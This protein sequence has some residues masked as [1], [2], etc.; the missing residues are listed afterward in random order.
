MQEQRAGN[1]EEQQTFT[2][3]RVAFYDA[4]EDAR[5]LVS[6]LGEIK[7]ANNRY[8]S[9]YVRAEITDLGSSLDVESSKLGVVNLN[10]KRTVLRRE[11]E[12]LESSGRLQAEPYVILGKGE[13]TTQDGMTKYYKYEVVPLSEA[14]QKGLV[15]E[16]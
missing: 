9:R 16:N 14:Q 7:T 2:S 3:P 13:A 5:L 10:L 1:T 12:Q 15:A 4:P 8:K 6:F 11:V